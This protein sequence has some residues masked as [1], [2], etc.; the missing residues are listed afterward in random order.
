MNNIFFS[1]NKSLHRRSILRGAGVSMALPWLSAMRPAF[2]AEDKSSGPKRFVSMTLGL[3]LVAENLNPQQSG[4][5][6]EPSRYLKMVD[7]LRD[8][9]TVVSGTS[10]PGVTGGHRAEASLLTANPVGS[11]GK[12]RNTISLDQLMARHLGDATRFPSLVLGSNGSNSPS[13]TE[14]GS[15]IPAESSPSRLFNRLFVDESPA[16]QKR[17]A[18]RVRQGRSIMDLVADDAKRLSKQLGAGDRDRLDLYFS[19]V[20]DLEKRLAASEA[21]ARRPKPKVNVAPPVDIGNS[22]DFVGRQALMSD[23]VRLALETDSTRFVSYHLGSSGG[24]VPVEGVNEGYHSLS[25]HGRDEEKLDQLAIVEE[26]IIS[27]WG[28]FLRDL[29][30][31]DEQGE[32]VLDNTCILLTSNLGNASNH[33][34]RNMPVLVAGGRF[35]HGQHLAFDKKNNYP[36]PNLYVN[37]LQHVGLET[38]QF[39]SSTGTMTGLERA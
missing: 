16:E 20:R 37:L 3:G 1:R 33:D 4:F 21:W 25:H 2:A 8:R 7:D 11:S 17:Q 27:S 9:F 12:A 31:T 5:G 22:A 18:A 35:R 30:E 36:L 15:M 10:H 26:N 14:N 19:S 34:N 23:M 13:Y 29:S 24:V 39:A 38:D 6:Y 32:S 28:Q